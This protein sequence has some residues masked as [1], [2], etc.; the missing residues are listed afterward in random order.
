MISALLDDGPVLILCPSTLTL[1]WQVELTDKLGIPAA[2]WSS[3]KKVW[4]DPKT[5]LPV[6]ARFTDEKKDK[7]TLTIG[8]EDW[9][10]EFDAKLFSRDLPAG[11]KLVEGKK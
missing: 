7:T 10:K 8:F 4:I 1:Q 9:N 2:V 6:R 5:D 11:F 3:G